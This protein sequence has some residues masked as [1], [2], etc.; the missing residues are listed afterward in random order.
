MMT[1]Y[2]RQQKTHRGQ[3][4]ALGLCGRRQGRDD[5][6]ESTGT[7]MLPHVKPM[8]GAS[9]TPEA[10]HAKPVLGTTRRDGW[11]RGGEGAQD[12]GTR[13]PA[14]ESHQCVAKTTTML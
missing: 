7:C 13:A 10:G 4:Q 11:G 14:G 3:E 12:G 1:L 6:R 9:S 2:A 5:L 8:A